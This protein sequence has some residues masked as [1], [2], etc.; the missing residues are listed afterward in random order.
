MQSREI[1]IADLPKEYWELIYS[2]VGETIV[3]A[4]QSNAEKINNNGNF[5]T[6]DKKF[7]ALI[8]FPE[9]VRSSFRTDGGIRN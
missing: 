1:D 5:L 6:S 9:N 7:L 3:K 8:D 2:R 4:I